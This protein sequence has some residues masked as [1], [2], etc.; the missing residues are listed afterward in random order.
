MAGRPGVSYQG[1]LKAAWNVYNMEYDIFSCKF[2]SEMREGSFIFCTNFFVFIAFKI[3]I[4]GKFISTM[5]QACIRIVQGRN[6]EYNV[7]VH[8]GA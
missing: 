6:I 4:D 7:T 3:C 8:T 2:C 5:D 1:N